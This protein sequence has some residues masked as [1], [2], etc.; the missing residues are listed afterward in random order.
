MGQPSAVEQIMSTSY[1]PSIDECSTRWPQLTV[2]TDMAAARDA[3][4]KRRK[5]D[6]PAPHVRTASIE[7]S[8]ADGAV[9]ILTVCGVII[10]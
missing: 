9:G 7:L 4:G 6:I 5:E 3:T 1:V 2:S 8:S 10:H